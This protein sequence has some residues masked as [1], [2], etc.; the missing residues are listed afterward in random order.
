MDLINAIDL[1]F[2]GNCILFTGAGAS[3]STKNIGD[4]NLKSANQLTNLLYEKCGLDSDGNLSYAVDE[5]LEQ[6]GEQSLITLLKEQYTVKTIQKEHEVLCSVDW[7]RIYTTNY[8]NVLETAYT[9]NGK[10][11]TPVTLSDRPYSFKDKKTLAIHLNGYI[12]NLTPNTLNE[13]FK[14]SEV[15]YLANDFISN[16]WGTLFRQ[17]LKTSDAIFFVGFSLNYDLDLKRVIYAT[18]D[19]L[20][21]C[22]FI[23][24]ENESSTTVKNVQKYGSPQCIGLSKFIQMIEEQKKSYIPKPKSLFRPL[25]FNI[26]ADNTNVPPDIR[27]KDFYKLLVEGVINQSILQYSVFSPQEFPY[28][29][30]REKL[31]ST[32]NSIENGAKNILITSDLGN[33]KTKFINGLS[34]LLKRKG[35]NV[36]EFN[37]Y[38][39]TL[40]RELE[41]ICSKV[42]KP[43]IIIESYS[44]HFDILSTI[45]NLRST[46][47][48]LIVSE[49]SLINDLVF[50]KYESKL[51]SDY[52]PVDLNVLTDSEIDNLILLIDKY[53]L[54]GEYATYHSHRK[55]EFISD[56]TQCRKNIRLLLLKLLN[57]PDIISRFNDVISTIQNK[58]NYYEAIIL[59]LVSKVFNFNL[60]LE[61]LIYA[62]DDEVLNKHSF[63]KDPVVREFVNFDENRI[64]V[65][66]A[67]LSEAI[68]SNVISS[69]GIVDTLIK[70]CKRLDNRRDDQ[71]IR[72]I[73]RE[74]IS[75][76]SLQRILQKDTAEYKFNILRF[77]EEI[78]NMKHCQSNPHYWL[79]YAIARLAERDYGLADSYFQ[80]AYAYASRLDWFDPYQIDNHYARHLIENEIYNGDKETAMPQF[81]KAHKVLSNPNDKN[82]TRHYPFKVAQKYFPFYEKYFSLLSKQDK[83]IFLHSCKEILNRIDSYMQSV[84]NYRI[85]R[86][87]QEA[88]TLLNKI[89]EENG[90]IKK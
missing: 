51:D 43:I 74:I 85:K 17:D 65:K 33:G 80:N 2:E 47:L 22:F 90:S 61:D 63:Q 67:V 66:S 24:S 3:L 27:D 19:L 6:Y 26:P 57:S 58:K 68:L 21:K 34:Y 88:K 32:I 87:V 1:I 82:K 55:R 23:L 64:V 13:E 77:F 71:N 45:K 37:K 50:P 14:L 76:S 39:A 52:Y 79:Q 56:P 83:V 4:E 72:I 62:L 16:D 5:Y 11:L 9:K 86:E 41:E 54:W 8:D 49:R 60:E 42:S 75:F 20:D 29:L 38:Y 31:D 84:E 40:D 48:V 69:R 28:Y 18:P 30:Y 78:R 25:C 12:N 89:I 15:S 44:H 7:K 59:I 53:G 46:D 81:L 10:I 70:V 73:L 36:F 35:Y